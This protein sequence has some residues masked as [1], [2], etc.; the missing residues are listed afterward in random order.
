MYFQK[1]GR[2]SEKPRENF[3]KNLAIWN[4]VNIK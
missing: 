4:I 1:Q 2:N 3:P